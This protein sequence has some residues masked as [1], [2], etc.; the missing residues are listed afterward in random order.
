MVHLQQV[1]KTYPAAGDVL[2]IPALQLETGQCTGL[3]GNNGAGKT[4]LLKALLDLI[5]LDD[6]TITINGV[7]AAGNNGWKAWVG[8]FLD[9]SFLIPFL[10]PEEHFAFVGKTHGL[11]D[12]DVQQRLLPL[13]PFFRGEILGGKKH[14]RDL[15][16]GNQAKVGIAAAL[17]VRPKLLVLDEPFAHLDP[18]SQLE[19][20]RLLQ[21]QQQEHG[22]TVLLS[23]HSLAHIQQICDRVL[24]LEKGQLRK[25][26]PG[27]TTATFEEVNA[28]F[29]TC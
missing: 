13:A 12:S 25:D 11:S 3:L 19:L 4:T 22:T 8:A 7:L 14:I 29:A 27:K 6:G 18:S 1:R 5:P 17:L 10:R 2:N 26:L 15:S 23:S 21:G 9:G 24:L 28:Y 16:E 20:N